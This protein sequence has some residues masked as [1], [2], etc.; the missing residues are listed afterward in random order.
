MGWAEGMQYTILWAGPRVCNTQYY[1]LG[2]GYAI[3]NIMGW[4]EGMQYTILWAGLR[5]CNTQY[6]CTSPNLKYFYPV[7]SLYFSMARVN[8]I[9]SNRSPNIFNYKC[10]KDRTAAENL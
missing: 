8:H 4:A 3:H 10:S 6:Q 9:S 1:G 5:V 2:W 7:S